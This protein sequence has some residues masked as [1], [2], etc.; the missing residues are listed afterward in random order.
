VLLAVQLALLEALATD[1]RV[2]L[3]VGP[4]L[5]ARGDAE[6]RALAR[7]LRRLA[8]VVQ[9]VQLSGDDGPWAEHATKSIA[10]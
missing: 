3:L 4:D 9:V 5:P 8:S 10:L 6:K 1:R 2:P 7:A